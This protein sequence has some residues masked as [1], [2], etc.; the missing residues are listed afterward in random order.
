MIY[1]QAL[2]VG[3]L[4][5]FHCAGMCGPIALALPLRENSWRTKLIS[6]LLYN[7]GRIF[8]YALLGC[9]FGILGYGLAF[10]GAQQFVSIFAGVLMILSIL[11]PII[12]RSFRFGA[13]FEKGLSLFSNFF[14]K[15][16]GF[17]TYFST[18]M[19][20]TLNGFLPCGLVYIALAGAVVSNGPGAGAIYM[21]LFGMGTLP[22]LLTVSM[23]GNLIGIRFRNAVKK[24]IP[25]AIIIIGILF[26]LRGLNL[27]IPYVSPSIIPHE[28]LPKCC[29]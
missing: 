8:T 4:G 15:L 17:R 10:W 25:Y 27:G 7:F 11:F 5:S 20:G 22:V 19:I 12:F 3:L 23:A 14:G 24:V 28:P 21:M 2:I 26:I 6:G 16:F 9:T 1:I 18:F 29:H 13:V